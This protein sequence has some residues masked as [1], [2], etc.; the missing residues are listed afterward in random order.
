MPPGRSRAAV[1][2]V[3]VGEEGRSRLEAGG[4]GGACG[5]RGEQ[6]PAGKDGTA[7]AAAQ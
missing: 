4:D 3:V 5:Q 1:S 7:D 2:T 6:P